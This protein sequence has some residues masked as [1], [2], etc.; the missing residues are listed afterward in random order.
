MRKL[1]VGM[2]VRTLFIESDSPSE[3]G[4]IESF[5]NKMRDELPN[6]GRIDTI[7]EAKI[8]YGP[9][10]QAAQKSEAE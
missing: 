9:L 7:R 1:L 10:N 3:N 5:N 4:Y 6:K 2:E 8:S